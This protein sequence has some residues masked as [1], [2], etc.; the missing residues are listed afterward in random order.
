MWP[1]RRRE[2][3]SPVE[4][5][6]GGFRYLLAIC[7][8]RGAW[9]PVSLPPEQRTFGRCA[10]RL[11][12]LVGMVPSKAAPIAAFDTPGPWCNHR[13][14]SG[15]K[16]ASYV[17]QILFEKETVRIFTDARGC[18]HVGGIRPMVPVDTALVENLA[19]RAAPWPFA[20]HVSRGMHRINTH[21]TPAWI[22]AY[23]NL[24][25]LSVLI[26][27]PIMGVISSS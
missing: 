12:G 20:L 26:V 16:F 11:P 3:G 21:L 14:V 13:S 15:P 7:I 18:R 6:R 17:T 8:S 5:A 10:G 1:I 23:C 19:S 24:Y 2:L 25:Y 27:T 9:W 22:C 4:H